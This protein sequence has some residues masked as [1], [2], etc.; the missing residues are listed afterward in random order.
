MIENIIDYFTNWCNYFTLNPA[1]MD[2]ELTL[3]FISVCVTSI[4]TGLIIYQTY[5]NSR[6]QINTNK[7]IAEI[8]KEMQI[9]NLKIAQYP[10][11]MECLEYL[12]NLYMNIPNLYDCVDDFVIKEFNRLITGVFE[13]GGFF[14]YKAKI[15]ILFSNQNIDL[16]NITEKN[17]RDVIPE[18]ADYLSL[19]YR[20]TDEVKINLK[21]ELLVKLDLIQN[22]MISLINAMQAEI[23]IKKININ[24]NNRV[25][26]N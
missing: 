21:K 23:D 25:N 3:S 1:Y 24:I 4:L 6:I 22:E 2:R 11:Q 14:S 20:T 15:S 18:I 12:M 5:K 19:P 8:Q 26:L 9:R 10:F 7:E 17:I 16:Y 13:I